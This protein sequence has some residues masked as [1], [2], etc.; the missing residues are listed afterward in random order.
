M[1]LVVVPGC[2]CIPFVEASVF[3]CETFR[4]PNSVLMLASDIVIEIL[5]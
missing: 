2:P 4:V 1:G 3:A 5:V